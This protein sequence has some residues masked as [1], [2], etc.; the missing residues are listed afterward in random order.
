K[1]V[2]NISFGLLT[3]DKPYIFSGEFHYQRLPV[4]ELWLDVFQKFKANGL[5]SV[6]LY[7]FWSYHS[8]SKDVYDLE[9]AGKNVQL[10]FDLAKGMSKFRGH[11]LIRTEAGLYVIARPG[12]YSNAETNGGGLALWTS[13]G[14]GGVLR[15][16]DETY[17]QAWLP[18]IEKLNSIIARNQ[19]TEGGPIILYQ[20]ENELS[21]T[22]HQPNNTLV[23]YMEQLEQAA[24]DSG[25]VIPLTSNEKGERSESWSTDYEDVGGAVNVYGLDSYPGGFSC[26]NINSGFS[27]VRNYYQWFQNYSYTQPQFWPEFEAGYFNAWGSGSFYDQCLAEH[28]P[29]YADV[30]FKNNIGQRGTLMSLYM[31]YGGTNWGNLA[32]PVVYT[33]YDYSAPLRETREVQPKFSQ[34]KLIGLFVRVS[35][36]LLQTDMESNGTGNAVSTPDIW[37]WVLRNHETSAGFY[38]LQHSTSSSRAITNF[39]VHLNTTM[40]AITVPNVQL[41]GRQSKII[42]TD[43]H[44]ANHT[45]LYSSADILTYASF[46]NQA[47]LVM[48]LQAGQTG[49]FAFK[50][51]VNISASENVVF[52]SS[53]VP[54][55][56][57]GTYLR[58]SWTQT[59]G[60]AV[61][62]FTNGVLLYLLDIP[63]AWTFFAPPTI[64][65][66]NAGSD[67]Q[68]F[69]IGPYL[70][71]N[72]TQNGSVVEING[73]NTNTTIVE[74]YVGDPCVKTIS[75]NNRILAT[76][77]TAHGSLV[78]SLTGIQDRAVDLPSLSIWS[79]AD[80][81]PEIAK[82]YDDSSWKVCNKSSTLSPVRPLTLPVLYS[83]DYGYYTGTKIYRGY[84]SGSTAVSAN[85]TAQNG[86]ASGW[87]AWLNGAFIGGHT[88]NATLT[89]TSA[90]LTFANVSLEAIN[91]LTIVVD[92]TG[93]DETSTAHGV[94]NPR[95][96][97]GVTI[98]ASDEKKLD[99]T[100]WKIQGNAGGSANIDPVRGPMNEGGLHGERRG[101]H[102]PGYVPGSDFHTA[103]PKEGINGSGI[104]WYITNFTLDIDEDLDVPLGLELGAPEGTLA[105]VQFWINGYHVRYGKYIPQIGPQTR[106][107]FP[108]GIVNNRGNNT[109]AISLWA[110][111]EA[112]ARLDKV[113][114]I[115]YGVY[116]SGFGFN[117]D[118]SALQPSWTE[119]RLNYN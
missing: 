35:R 74:V 45:L 36:D 94:E 44:F 101:W 69:V 88:G 7:F 58:F 42:V 48:Y 25:I 41:N 98:K 83:S 1:T 109:L 15:T 112:G 63:T 64:S 70:V 67:N 52:T 33:S 71:R 2:C 82:S 21:E 27:L 61:V 9:T 46:R 87:S 5:N 10:V 115:K 18:W 19:I 51:D 4:P 16:A 118:W 8:A 54:G 79:A 80:S 104:N 38:T 49:E 24:R 13:D 34:T 30:Y 17:H 6:T 39:S 55:N 100:Q 31:A 75:W 81:L 113:Q 76:N 59:S 73:D 110:Q 66:P 43:Y 107:P 106:F 28:D 119:E 114:L 91:V 84:F 32:A 116:E 96:L 37:T 12:P 11:K 97:L 85:I 3:A 53:R 56:N 95:G 92:Y 108:P 47:V 72:A 93:H 65:D 86:L 77:Q 14:S 57:T 26:T 89:T 68:I 23:L 62:Q 105:S 99:F 117:R 22:S 40:G 60:K 90:I 103:T 29:A 111:S 50:E 102:L 78:A 20:I